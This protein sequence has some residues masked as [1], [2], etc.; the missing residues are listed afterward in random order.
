MENKSP[1]QIL[2]VNL[3]MYWHKTQVTVITINQQIYV[4]P[5]WL[6]II[7]FDVCWHNYFLR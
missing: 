2:A 4:L 7:I 5:E 3:G 6:S 1:E